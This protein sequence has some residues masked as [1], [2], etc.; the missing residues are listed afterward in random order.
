MTASRGE[1]KKMAKQINETEPPLPRLKVFGT[2]DG[3]LAPRL[4]I[5]LLTIAPR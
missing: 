3:T 1:T 2:E 4:N 5:K